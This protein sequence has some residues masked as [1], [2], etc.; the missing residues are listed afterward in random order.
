VN[1]AQGV[2]TWAL[3]TLML[4]A[5]DRVF[6]QRMMARLKFLEQAQWWDRERLHSERDRRLAEM[7]QIAYHEVPFY[8]EVFD[9][10]GVKPGNIRRAE[11][12]A[13]L[14]PVTKAMMRPRFPN[15][16]TRDTGQK[17]Y[18]KCSSGS[19][20]APFCIKEDAETAGWYRASSLL[21]FEWAGW[22][23]GVPHVQLGINLKRDRARAIKDHLLRTHYASAYHLTDADLD[24]SL[25]AL[26]E[27]GIRFIFGYP[28]SVYLLAKRAAETGWN[29]PMQAVVTWGDN[30]FAHY[31]ATIEQAFR[32]RVY[33][34]Y[35]CGEGMEVA[36]QCGQG[37]TY[38]INMLD[39]IV[40][41]I[42][43][44]GQAV[45]PGMPGNILL[46]R[47]HPGATPFIRY[48]LGDVGI[49][50]DG[51]RCACGRG[52]DTLRAIQ[53]RDTDYV[54]TPGGNR[55]IVHFFTG[56]LEHF[57]EVRQFQAIQERADLMLLK[58][59]PMP[60]YTEESSRQIIAAL[61]ARGA[62]ISIEIELVDDIPLT[63]AG[64][65]RFIL[66]RLA[67]QA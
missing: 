22:Q 36:C 15:G 58:I 51:D 37:M 24:A 33:D 38:H 28:S 18:D 54:L 42:D 10:A 67:G 62:D 25:A 56:I 44:D 43:D 11:D 65:R 17:P 29:Q 2:Y 26:D 31:R 52:F 48:K 47:L 40:E 9:E 7:V 57:L 20:G 8:R 30:L 32:T 13:R 19:T 61:R 23:V 21:N 35:G 59:I 60:D 34:K 55:L 64:K 46:T 66:N 5:G 50:G 3:R 45:T 12:L 16:I 4:P 41:Y 27:R 49:A 53:G 39:V 63:P 1:P 14:P 6:G